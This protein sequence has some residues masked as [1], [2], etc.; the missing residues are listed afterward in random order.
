MHFGRIRSEIVQ[1]HQL[2]TYQPIEFENKVIPAFHPDQ[3]M[4][5]QMHKSLNH[6]Q[7]EITQTVALLQQAVSSV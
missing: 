6:H 4:H 7:Q 1:S 2:K 3:N 5:C